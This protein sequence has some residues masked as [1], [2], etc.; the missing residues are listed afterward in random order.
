M[1][2]EDG[3]HNDVESGD[4][5]D[6]DVESGDGDDSESGEQGDENVRSSWGFTNLSF[7]N[8]L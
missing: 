5:D 3:E 1:L 4:G 8:E 6:N 7:T 2:C